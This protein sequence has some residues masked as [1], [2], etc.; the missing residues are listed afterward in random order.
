MRPSLTVKSSNKIS[1]G[2]GTGRIPKSI[3]T[4]ET[5]GLK[6]PQRGIFQGHDRAVIAFFMKSLAKGEGFHEDN[7]LYPQ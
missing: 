2:H 3:T 1:G 7:K 5:G 4:N 6:I